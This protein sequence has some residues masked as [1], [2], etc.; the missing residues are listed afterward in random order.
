MAKRNDDYVFLVLDGNEFEQ[1]PTKQTTSGAKI[2]DYGILKFNVD[3]N[4]YD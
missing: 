3:H 2:P 4:F 1:K